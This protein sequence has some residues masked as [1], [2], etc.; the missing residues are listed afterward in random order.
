MAIGPVVLPASGHAAWD[1]LATWWLSRYKVSTQQTHATYLPR[2]TTSAATPS[3]GT[4]PTK[5]PASSPA[6]PADP[7]EDEA[8]ASPPH[9][10][11]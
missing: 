7:G 2:A 1:D 11:N 10:R 9:C 5:S 8:H 4:P 3:S 6:G